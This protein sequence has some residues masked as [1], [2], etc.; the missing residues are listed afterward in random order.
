MATQSSIPAWRTPWTEEPG[1]SWG[2]TESDTT[3]QLT[4]KHTHRFAAGSRSAVGVGDRACV[5]TGSG[6]LS[7]A[8]ASACSMSRAGPQPVASGFKFLLH[9]PPPSLKGPNAARQTGSLPCAP[10]GPSAAALL[11]WLL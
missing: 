10:Q 9:Q 2:C 4:H 1:G 6:G 11:S 8:P 3:E 5:L 7:G